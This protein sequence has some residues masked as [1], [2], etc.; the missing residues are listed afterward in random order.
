MSGEKKRESKEDK[1]GKEKGEDSV[2]EE[3]EEEKLRKNEGRPLRQQT[4][5]T[6]IIE[7]H[8]TE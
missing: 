3:E 1:R 7:Y 2:E 8:I 6:H 5:P 4:G